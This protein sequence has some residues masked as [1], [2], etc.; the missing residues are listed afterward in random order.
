MFSWATYFQDKM[1]PYTKCA[2]ESN[3]P[4]DDMFPGQYVPRDNIF[5]RTK[6]SYR[7]KM[8]PR[9]NVPQDKMFLRT[10]GS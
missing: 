7:K 9:T 8:F 10:K 6:C 5:Q 2:H 3:V 1:F 4:M